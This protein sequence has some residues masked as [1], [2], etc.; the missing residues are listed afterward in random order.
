MVCNL[1]S[2]TIYSVYL[3]WKGRVRMRI[4]LDMC[5][6]CGQ[7]R[8]ACGVANE[9]VESDKLTTLVKIKLEKLGHTV[10]RERPT[11]NWHTEISS[12]YE[13]AK[14]ANLW[15]ADIFVSVHNN[16]GGGYG[17]EVLT[18]QGEKTQMATRYLQY[19]LNHGGSTH[20]GYNHKTIDGAVKDGSEY[21]VIRESHMEAI[22]LENFYVD[23]QSDYNFFKANIEMF[24]NAIVYGIT[25]VDLKSNIISGPKKEKHRNIIVYQDGA[26][27][28]KASAEFMELIL[29]FRKQDAKAIPVSKVNQYEGV[30]IFVIG[31]ARVNANKVLRGNDRYETAENVLEH[32]IKTK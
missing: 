15:G 19:I 5:H 28:D 29:N 24:A 14:R 3:I 16:A 21:I 32:L 8:G 9:E 6:G 26:E 10:R 13:R 1:H 12:C 22:I 31:A 27:P 23:T 11:D 20:D 30:S 4:Y 2:N 25:G 7:D 17:S 18:Y